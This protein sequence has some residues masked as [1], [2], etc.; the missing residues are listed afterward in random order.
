M[1]FNEYVN[2]FCY[3]NRMKRIQLYSFYLNNK[4]VLKN[5]A[6]FPNIYAVLSLLNIYVFLTL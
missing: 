1:L 4:Y 5:N 6:L 2:K 3:T